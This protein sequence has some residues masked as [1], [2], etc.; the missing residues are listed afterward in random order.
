MLG[1]LPAMSLNVF[2]IP[3]KQG[4]LTNISQ[5]LLPSPM[6]IASLTQMLQ[7]GF[8]EIDY[9]RNIFTQPRI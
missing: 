1:L 4:F 3:D 6:E 9:I 8:T 7:W 5:T 2:S